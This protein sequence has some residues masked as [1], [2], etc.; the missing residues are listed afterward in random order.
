MVFSM[1][2]GACKKSPDSALGV[3]ESLQSSI[4]RGDLGTVFSLLP[5]SYQKDIDGI[6]QGY[7]KAFDK[8]TYENLAQIP[9][10]VISGVDKGKAKLKKDKMVKRFAGKKTDLDQVVKGLQKLWEALEDGGITSHDTMTSLSVQ[11]FLN[12]S[13]SD[14]MSALKELG[15]S[16]K[17]ADLSKFTNDIKAASFKVVKEET[18]SATIEVTSGKKTE[19][20]VF[21]KVEGKWIPDVIK[22]SWSKAIKREKKN[23][24][25]FT[26]SMK[27]RG[28]KYKKNSKKLLKVAEKFEKSGNMK[29]IMGALRYL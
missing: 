15:K 9:G 2:A 13:G 14:I 12:K 20:V 6:A 16:S 18:D 10:K 29:D 23:L 25:R 24:K 17:K 3:M 4:N 1:L 21:V 7:A 8:K 19:K 5:A 28:K 22:K 27:K 26:K 11:K